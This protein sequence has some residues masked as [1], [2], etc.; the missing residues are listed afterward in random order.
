M[1]PIS[2]CQPSAAQ[3]GGSP[4]FSTAYLRLKVL[5][6]QAVQRGCKFR[7]IGFQTSVHPVNFLAISAGD[8]NHRPTIKTKP[9]TSEG[10][11]ASFS[12]RMLDQHNSHV[13]H[14]N[15]FE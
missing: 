5:A 8:L 15:R 3:K 14:P 11:S 4:H 7:C 6:Q 13:P 10:D 1:S 9:D 12:F 2:D